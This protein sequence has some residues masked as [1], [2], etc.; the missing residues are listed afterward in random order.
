MADKRLFLIDGSA[1]AY[2]SYFAFQRNPLVNSKGEETSLAYGFATTIVRL[3]NNEGPTH[4]A[5]IFD[6]KGPTFRHKMFDQYK[7][8]RKAMPEEMVEQLP[9]LD[10]MLD[11]MKVITLRKPGLEADDI[12]ASIATDAPQKGWEVVIVSGDKDLLQLVNDNV[13]LF[14]LRK[15]SETG[16]WFDREAVKLKMGVYPERVLDLL[17]LMGDSSD[18]IPGVSGVGAK[19]ALQLLEEFGS[20]DN[21]LKNA[22]K[23]ERQKLRESIQNNEEIARLSY[24]LVTLDTSVKCPVAY[25]EMRL[26]DLESPELHKLF[27]ELEFTGLSKSLRTPTSETK[28]LESL[29]YR[30]IDNENDLKALI[31]QLRKSKEFA[32]DTETDGLDP[33]SCNLVGISISKKE[34]EGYYIPVGHD[35]GANLDKDVCLELFNPVLADPKIEKV[36]MNFKFD[37][38]VMTRAGYEIS[39]FDHDP[40]LA[41]YVLDPTS[42]QHGLSALALKHFNYTM[43]PISDLIGTGK[44]QKTF[45]TVPIDKATFYSAEDADFTLRL[46]RK[47]EPMVEEMGAAKLLHEIELPLSRVLAVMERNGVKIDVKMLEKMSKEMASDIEDVVHDIYTLAGHEFNINSPSQL[48]EIL[49]KE[50]Q[51]KPVRKTAKTSAYSTDV[52]V[53][54]ELAKIHDL[55]KRV[56]DYRHL[57]KLKSTYVDTLPALVNPETGRV[58][59][60]YNQA[61]AA[62]GRLSSTDPNLQNIPIKTEMGSH[63]RTAFVAADKNHILLAADYSQIELRILAHFSKDETLTESFREGE[64]VHSRTASEVYGVDLQDVTPDMRRVAKTANFAVIYGVSAYGLSQQSDMTVGESREFIKLY[65]ARYP[66]IKEFTDGVIAKAREEMHVTTLL[67]RRRNLP[68]INSKNHNIRQFAER[69]AVNTVIQGTAADMIKIAMIQ[70]QQELDKRESKMIMQVHDELVFDVKQTELADIRKVV[71]DKMENCLKLDVPVVV[72]VGVGDNWLDCK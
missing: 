61:V 40:M 71:T 55:P 23:I 36:A 17:A 27:L 62:T 39:G 37:Y 64:D 72:D 22:D 8:K 5:V 65:N 29:D 28:Q 9:R 58:H 49:F 32:F 53:L 31:K 46:S 14:N 11:K 41:S 44:K 21:V 10:E 26:P 56:L 47:L 13:K 30:T 7:A 52:N 1:L 69:T 24:K 45:N 50:L 3:V 43:Q 33:I 54:T 2:R 63:I 42:R 48:G 67:G 57:Q 4:L 20:F 51:L 38:H 16:E 34:G 19:T 70:I 15:T 35:E 12:I 59:T 6:S 60:S 68:E 66:K 18:N 25:D